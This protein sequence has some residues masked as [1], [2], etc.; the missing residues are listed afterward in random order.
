MSDITILKRSHHF[1]VTRLTDRGKAVVEGFARQYIQWGRER[2]GFRY[3]TAALKVFA[4]A[5][6]DRKEYRFHINCY[7]E[8]EKHLAIN[9]L[10][11]DLVTVIDEAPPAF[12][13][14]E[15]K[16]FDQWKVFDYQE[17][18]IDYIMK[19]GEPVSKFVDL[20]TG[21]G[22]SFC[23]MKSISNMGMRAV[24]I[25]KAMYL[26]KWVID[27]RKT[28]DIT[29]EDLMVIR[30]S[31][32]LMALLQMAVA[33]QL[34][35]KVVLLSNKTMQN[36]LKLYERHG[37]EI[38]GMGYACTPDQFFE[39]LQAGIRVIDEVHQDF[40]LNFKIDLY[41]NV[42]KSLSL[43]ATLLADD[44]FLNKMYE[45]AYPKDERYKGP[46]YDK[47]IASTAYCFNFREPNKIRTKD[48]ASK[49]YSHHL[50]EQS[51]IRQPEVCSNFLEMID[52]VLRVKYFDIKSE[53][54]KAIIFC[55]SIEMCS[56]VTDFLKKRHKDMDVRR[57]VE[58]DP[59]DNLMEA[60]IR[61][62]TLLSAGTAVDIPMLRTTILTTA[63]SSSQSNI[64]GFGRLRKMPSGNTPEFVYF[65]GVDIPK[66]VEYHDKKQTM[67]GERSV[68]YFTTYH[69]VL[70]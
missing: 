56:I 20:Q 43:S 48:P 66:H 21:K 37:N 34:D 17:P 62:T 67:I 23:A 9:F 33:G 63:V 64:Q 60:D 24:Y 52:R 46:A 54:E 13:K 1:V 14:I 35:F 40:H 18:V 59:Y 69:N 36:W 15:L 61:V 50:F 42:A 7:K 22:K 26:E 2:R 68:S 28:Y 19:E 70:L 31:N 29:I 4:A 27:I 39:V 58:E 45:L 57:Y 38:L 11:G 30:G 44:A 6:H 55:A 3:V 8:F 65:V 53:G 41:T 16:V 51:V 32:Q 49:N 12:E 25:V 47:Y 10:S 5:T